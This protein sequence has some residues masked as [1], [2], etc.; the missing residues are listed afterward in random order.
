MS[1]RRARWPNTLA[2]TYL[3][4]LASGNP[5]GRAFA[6]LDKN[7]ECGVHAFVPGLQP[8]RLHLIEEGCWREGLLQLRSARRTRRVS[9]FSHTPG[10]E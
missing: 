5:H 1:V 4:R 9:A 3:G 8:R 10:T 2:K 7:L 6:E